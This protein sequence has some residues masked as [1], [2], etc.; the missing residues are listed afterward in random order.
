MVKKNMERNKGATNRPCG[1]IEGT[2]TA[3]GRAAHRSRIKKQAVENDD[4]KLEKGKRVLWE[5]FHLKA[6]LRDDD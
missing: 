4:K 6:H 5:G 1:R 2:W 3:S